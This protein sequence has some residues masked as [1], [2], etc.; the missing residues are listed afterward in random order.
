MSVTPPDGWTTSSAGPAT[1]FKRF[2]FSDYA[3]LR[4]FLDDMAALAEETGVHPDNI[5][6]GRNYVNVTLEAQAEQDV[7]Q[8]DFIQRL[9]RLSERD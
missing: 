3:R 5:G 6:F 9:D 7:Q 4:R 1:W 2:E 8:G